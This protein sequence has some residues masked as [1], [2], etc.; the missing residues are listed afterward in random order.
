MEKD[1]KDN[2]PSQNKSK[3]SIST[4]INNNNNTINNNTEN[5]ATILSINKKKN[6]NDNLID[7]SHE[8]SKGNSDEDKKKEE[9]EKEKDN[10]IEVRN[11]NNPQSLKN[12]LIKK[13]R[14]Q[15]VLNIQKPKKNTKELID[16][17]KD[18]DDKKSIQNNDINNNND[19]QS[20]YLFLK[21]SKINR[22]DLDSQSN[23]TNKNEKDLINTSN[24]TSSIHKEVENDDKQ[25]ERSEEF[26]NI[27]NIND[28]KKEEENKKEINLIE[29]G[30]DDNI[31]SEE[32][33]IDNNES[34]SNNENNEKEDKKSEI[35]I[36]NFTI[37]ADKTKNKK[38]KN[39]KDGFK[40]AN[41][42]KN[43]GVDYSMLDSAIR[44]SKTKIKK[45]KKRREVEEVGNPPTE[46]DKKFNPD[47]REDI[48]DFKE[49]KT[50]RRGFCTKFYSIIK[51]NS[52]ILFGFYPDHND[53]FTKVSVLILS[54]NIYIFFNIM[55]MLKSPSLHLYIGQIFQ[56]KG[57]VKDFIFN[58]LFPFFLIIPIALI[59]RYISVKE[60]IDIRYGEYKIA[61]KENDE[62]KRALKLHIIQTELSVFKNLN[63]CRAC[64]VLI[65]GGSFL[66][67]NGY[68]LT[69]FLGIYEH[70]TKCLL[71]N[72]LCGI[73]S[74]IVL[75]LFYF[76][77]L[78]LLKV[79]SVCLNCKLL[80]KISQRLNPSVSLYLENEIEKEKEKDEKDKNN[81]NVDNNNE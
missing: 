58:L 74:S 13:N 52:T 30:D 32:I 65:V 31:E 14:R 47:Y 35:S 25:S 41:P 2:I 24:I 15:G 48:K 27:L 56:E 54:L 81:G 45:P 1:N 6:N 11:K 76:F 60:F 20:D 9:D 50:D 19:K 5:E 67:F 28:I 17:N 10:I 62:F 51:N 29:D 43:S 75:S 34:E 70:S 79:F 61:K 23:F 37:K 78:T 40:N 44:S 73:G 12:Q 38:K 68:L 4:N 3:P 66:F 69:S 26:N 46:D 39:K 71:I 42:P 16:E 72:T 49:F 8:E 59:K 57:E 64:M 63:Q 80:Y 21:N 33:N 7:L 22:Y 36:N 77:I 55:I 18:N 53:F